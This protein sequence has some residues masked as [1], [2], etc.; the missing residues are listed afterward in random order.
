MRGGA[1]LTIR[2]PPVGV[3]PRLI[4]LV[5]A[6]DESQRHGDRISACAACHTVVVRAGFHACFARSL[7]RSRAGERCRRS[8]AAG[9]NFRCLRRR[10]WPRAVVPVRRDVRHRSV[11]GMRLRPRTARERRAARRASGRRASGRCVSGWC[12]GGRRANGRFAG[13]RHAERTAR[14]RTARE[15]RTLAR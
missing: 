10:G 12:E 8:D 5:G 2:D 3:C 13:G 6:H 1:C 11:C 4:L 7:A 9:G 14:E 15:R